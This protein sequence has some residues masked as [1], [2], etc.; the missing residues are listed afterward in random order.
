VRGPH[1]ALKGEFKNIL[2]SMLSTA[3]EGEIM[4]TQIDIQP[5]QAGKKN[6]EKLREVWE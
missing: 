3:R 2:C 1:Y 5:E 4:S 6:T